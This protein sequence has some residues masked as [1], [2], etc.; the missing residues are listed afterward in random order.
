MHRFRGAVAFKIDLGKIMI[1]IGGILVSALLEKYYVGF[2]GK[3][4]NP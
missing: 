1:V 4:K 3:I 2:F